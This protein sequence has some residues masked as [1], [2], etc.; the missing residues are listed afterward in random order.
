M[1]MNDALR[2]IAV[3]TPSVA[4]EALKTLRVTG[5]SRQM[6]YNWL[7]EQAFRD[8]EANWSAE[9]RAAIIALVEPLDDDTRGAVIPPIRV[10]ESERARA[11][12]RADEETDGNLSELIRR[13]LFS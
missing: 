8:P 9:E 1:D 11:Q 4:S 12:A 7:I 2:L 10:T 13:L 6:R 3:R 5:L